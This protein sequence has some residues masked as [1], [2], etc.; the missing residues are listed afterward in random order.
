[1]DALTDWFRNF[2]GD[3]R[4]DPERSPYSVDTTQGTEYPIAT[5]PAGILAELGFSDS[6]IEQITGIPTVDIRVDFL[7]STPAGQALVDAARGTGAP[8]VGFEPPPEIPFGVK[9]A[10][11]TYTPRPEPTT[12]PTEL[13][14]VVEQALPEGGP[15][16]YSGVFGVPQYKEP[17]GIGARSPNPRN[18]PDI[19]ALVATILDQNIISDRS[20]GE[21][22]AGGGVP[23]RESVGPYDVARL[24]MEE[25]A[26]LLRERQRGI[27]TSNRNI[28]YGRR[29]VPDLW[30]KQ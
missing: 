21:A 20:Y 18:K 12:L 13:Q 19:E 25:W 23:M 29:L 3:R 24:S 15:R 27:N 4:R 16:Q 5:L 7:T 1:M 14:A 28:R 30:E 2:I 9:A 6:I 17:Q 11:G 26:N 10:D 8:I 22:N